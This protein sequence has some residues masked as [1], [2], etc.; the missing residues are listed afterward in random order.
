MCLVT[1][2]VDFAFNEKKNPKFQP[3]ELIKHI[4]YDM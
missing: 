4:T 2:Y 1:N 3:Y